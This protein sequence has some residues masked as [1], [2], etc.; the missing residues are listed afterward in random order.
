MG[1]RILLAND[2]GINSPGLAVL[3][4]IARGISDD[5]WIVAPEDEQSGAAHSLTINEP[6]RLRAVGDRRYA[7]RGTPT[8]CVM[9]AVH[10]ILRG[11]KRP[12]LLL[13]G[14]NMGANL[15]EDV[16][17][18]GTVAAAMEGCLLGI[19]SIAFSQ[20]MRLSAPVHWGTPRKFA[21]GIIQRVLSVDWPEGVLMNV[22]F[23]DLPPEAVTGVLTSLQGQRDPADLIIEERIDVRGLPYYW[24]GFRR[25]PF[26]PLEDTDF[27][28][29]D[30]GAISV[31]PLRINLSDPGTRERIRPLLND[32]K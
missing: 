32:L 27:A 22:N 4:E 16:T 18:S 14:I 3:E 2:D 19:R 11:Q 21:P 29:I 5:V 12:D 6:L 13:S 23:P 10:H 9:L 7:V 30:Q 8:D 1:P 31:S 28:V 17:Y 15:G 24:I 25:N 20:L 26:K